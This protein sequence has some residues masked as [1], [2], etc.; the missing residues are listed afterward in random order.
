MPKYCFRHE[1]Q[2]RVGLGNLCFSTG[3]AGAVASDAKAT[4][5]IAHGGYRLGC[6]MC[7][8]YSACS[9]LVEP[10]SRIPTKMTQPIPAPCIWMGQGDAVENALA[11]AWEALPGGLHGYFFSRATILRRHA[12]KKK[13]VNAAHEGAESGD[14]LQVPKAE[15]L[16]EFAS[17][18]CSCLLD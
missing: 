13:Q 9:P 11:V 12:S 10:L 14:G 3:A 8:G 4:H 15:F 16:R 6:D 5:D 2:I 17:Q 7:W 1:R 18:C